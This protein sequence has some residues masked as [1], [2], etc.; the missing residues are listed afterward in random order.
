MKTITLVSWC[1][2]GLYTA[3]LIGLL[4]F[5]RSDSSDDRT[6]SGY[7][8][9]LF[10]PLGILAAINLLP[11]PFTRIMV[12]V[13][14]AAPAVMTVIMLIAS[15]IIQKWRNASWAD[16]D[17][18]RANGSYYFKDAP[19][20]KLAAAIAAL[21]AEQLSTDLAQP[22]PELN[23]SGRDQVTLLDFVALQGFEAD[24]AQLIAC[25]DVLLKSGAQIDNGDPKHS[26]TH[27]RVIDYDP[28]ILKWFLE[29][30]ADANARE[31][32]TGT[33]ILFQAIH[34]DRSD[35]TRTEKV[36]LLLEHGADPNII[37]PQQDKLVIITSMLLSAASAEAWDICN[38]MLDYGADPHY[39]TQSG[40]D[41]FQ[42]VDYQSKQFKSWGQIPPSGFTR[43]AE[44]L[45]A[46]NANGDKN[47]RQ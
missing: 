17:T 45:A 5:A 19:R 31:A 26:P 7:V 11:F 2:L 6:A 28:A 38:V 35:T 41:I 21:N 14:S 22:V 8:I 30:G 15:P 33:P 12:L 13:L 16:E 46:V 10:I 43:L 25:F 39:K 9:M 3:I 32:G 24:P 23:Q 36:R 18:A 27:F 4:L 47:T 42:A 37:P 44:R 20:Q 29:H 40:W 1:L 34:R